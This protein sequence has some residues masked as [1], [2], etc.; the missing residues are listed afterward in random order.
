MVHLLKP[1]DYD[2]KAHTQ[3]PRSFVLVADMLCESKQEWK[4]MIKRQT[5][6][7]NLRVCMQSWAAWQEEKNRFLVPP[8]S[9]ASVIVVLYN[10]KKEAHQSLSNIMR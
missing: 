2:E 9:A 7:L 1:S 3:T 5:T 8:K 6:P 10:E 4:Q